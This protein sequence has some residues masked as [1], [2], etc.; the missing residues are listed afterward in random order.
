MLLLQKLF[1]KYN[2][3]Y[4]IPLFGFFC[5]YGLLFGMVGA[6][7]RDGSPTYPAYDESNVPTPLERIGVILE[8]GFF[9]AFVV[10]HA[11]VFCVS[12]YLEFFHRKIGKLIKF[13]KPKVQTRLA[14]ASLSIGVIGQ[15]FFVVQAIVSTVY[16][17]NHARAKSHYAILLATF[18]V[19]VMVSLALNF[20]NYYIMGQYYRMY[21]NGERWN[22]FMISFVVKISWLVVTIA[23]AVACCV[24][25]VK[26]S[27]TPSSVLEW[28]FHF[29]YGFLMLFWT[30]DL[31]PLSEM[32][33]LQQNKREKRLFVQILTPWSREKSGYTVDVSEME[34]GRSEMSPTASP[35]PELPQP[36]G[37]N[38]PR[39]G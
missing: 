27:K 31:Y 25:Y 20:T 9:I 4:L 11:I 39:F 16:I 17:H 22:K 2:H 6:W 8:P 33:A 3:F 5:W 10:I 18:A 26:G 29:W 15:V 12:M 21:V 37:L 24:L 38:F 7:V 1:S 14:Y 34:S 30:Y 19:L 13:I 32:K 36:A 35:Q 23:L 28:C